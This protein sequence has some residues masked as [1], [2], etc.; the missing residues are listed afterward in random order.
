[1]LSIPLIKTRIKEF[2][3]KNADVS[4][5]GFI[6][7][8]IQG[9]WRIF[10]ARIYLRSCNH[11]GKLVSVN[12]KPII[13]NLGEMTFDDEV[14]IW[15]NIERSKLYTGKSGKLIVG[16]NSRLNG[17]HIDA[18]ELIHIGDTVQIGPYTIIMDSDFHDLKDHSK[19]GPSSPIYIEDDVWIATR[20]TILKGV[21]IGK[22]SVIAAGAIVTKD[23]PP[24]CVAAGTP[25]RVVK[26]IE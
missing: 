21:R 10:L 11:I 15:S 17:V 26:K 23:V 14:R 4:T 7:T 2:K 5:L 6:F 16:R 12:G 13:G 18:R 1:M 24:Y 9:V 20:V 8:L 22:G 25:A 3:A 19:D